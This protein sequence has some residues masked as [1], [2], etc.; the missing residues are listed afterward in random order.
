[1]LS[2]QSTQID[3]RTVAHTP[4]RVDHGVPDKAHMHNVHDLFVDFDHNF[5][6]RRNARK[7]SCTY[8][9]ERVRVRVPSDPKA[10]ASTRMN[11]LLWTSCRY[12]ERKVQHIFLTAC[13]IELL[14]WRRVFDAM[15]RFCCFLRGCS[16]QKLVL[17]LFLE[18]IVL[19]LSVVCWT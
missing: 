15:S 7:A 14:V 11:T 6:P 2:M 19:F 10:L 8:R 17:N 9:G 12:T 5:T 18:G 16:L 13:V 1:M 3:R 4:A